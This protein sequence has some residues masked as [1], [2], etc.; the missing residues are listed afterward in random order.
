MD[1]V[2]MTHSVNPG[3]RA[4]HVSDERLRA[5]S[6]FLPEQLLHLVGELAHFLRLATLSN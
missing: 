4:Y 2:F 3:C 1:P 6:S 5:C